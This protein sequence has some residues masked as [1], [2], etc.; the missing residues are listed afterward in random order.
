MK[1]A[2]NIYTGWV[3]LYKPKPSERYRT[4]Q[5]LEYGG[6]VITTYVRPWD[7]E[8]R[9]IG[10]ESLSTP[11]RVARESLVMMMPVPSERTVAQ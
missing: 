10:M 2:R 5:T 4:K 1:Q 7:I 9:A 8:V 3:Y 6:F 11:T